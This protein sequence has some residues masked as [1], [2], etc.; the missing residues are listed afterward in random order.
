MLKWT[1]WLK[2]R[3][4]PNIKFGNLEKSPKT[5]GEMYSG[6]EEFIKIIINIRFFYTV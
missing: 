2:K 5:S 4:K 1:T 3:K 6:F